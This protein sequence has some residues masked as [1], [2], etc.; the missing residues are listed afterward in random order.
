MPLSV[1]MTTGVLLAPV[2]SWPPTVTPRMPASADT[3]TEPV[4]MS[5]LAS[6]TLLCAP[7]TVPSLSSGVMTG[8]ASVWPVTVTVSVAVVVAPSAS[9]TV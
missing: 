4:T 6:I 2:T 1:V 5:P 8:G 9:T 7:V 3:V